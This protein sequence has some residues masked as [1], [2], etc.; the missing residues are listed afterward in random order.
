MIRILCEEV[1]ALEADIV[2]KDEEIERLNDSLWY[3]SFDNPDD[4]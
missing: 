2:E 1:F 3:A 4:I